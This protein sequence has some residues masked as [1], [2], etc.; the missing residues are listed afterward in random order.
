MTERAFSKS[1][2]EWYGKVVSVNDPDQDGRVQVRILG[3][4]DDISNIPDDM[5][6]WAKP[7]QDI[8][9]AAHNK[10]GTSPVGVI[11]G[12]IIGGYYMDADMQ[13]PVFTHTVAKAGDPSKDNTSTSDGQTTLEPGT[14][15]SPLG[16]RITTNAFVTRQGRDI[17][18]DD[19]TGS[20]GP[21]E[22]KDSDGVDVTKQAQQKTKFYSQPTVGSIQN[23]AGS[24]LQQ[25]LRVDPQ[26]I[27]R[28]K[29]LPSIP[30]I[31]PVVLDALRSLILIN[32]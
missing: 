7:A 15:S 10:M 32:D 20:Q 18:K 11:V 14:N 3:Q 23:A 21:Q 9:S 5:L 25:I 12:S 1:W 17:V 26:N 29:A 22:Q 19:Q 24:I 8:T 27:A 16:N 6:L 30:L 4:H 28:P 2:N 13:I 31:P